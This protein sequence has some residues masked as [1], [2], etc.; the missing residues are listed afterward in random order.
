MRI[1]MSVTNRISTVNQPKGGYVP[2]RLFVQKQYED[3]KEIVPVSSKDKSLFSIQGI[4]VDYLTR[5]MVSGDIMRAFSIALAGAKK[6]DDYS[7]CDDETEKALA[8]LSGIKGLDKVSIRNA[9]KLSGYDTAFRAGIKSYRNIDEI[10]VTDEMIDNIKILVERGVSYLEEIGPVI[11]SEMTFE[12]GYTD[13]VSSGDGDYLTKDSIIDFKVSTKPFSTHW[14][15][16]LLMYYLLG[17]H[18]VHSKTYKAIKKLCIFNPYENRSYTANVEDI[19]DESKYIVSHEVL[20]YQMRCLSHRWDK[21]RGAYEDYSGW[22]KVDGS[23]E[24]VIKD[25]LNKRVLNNSF[26]IKKYKDGIHNI[27]VDDYW[28]CL[29]KIDKEYKDTIRPIFR[30]TDHVTMIKRNGYVMFLSVSEK[31]ICSV[32]NGGRL[33]KATFSAVYYYEN[34]ER[35]SDAVVQRFSKYWDALRRISKQLQSLTPTKE[36]L[37]YRYKEYLEFGYIFDDPVKTFEEWYESTGKYTR[38]DGKIHGCIVDIDYY[39]HIYVNPFDGTIVPYSAISMY[40]KNVYKNVKSLMAK[41][42]PEMLESL[43]HLALKEPNSLISL[44]SKKPKMEI[45]SKGDE[46]DDRFVKVYSH[47]MYEVS[48]RLKPLQ[49]IYDYKLV[50]VWYDEI[51][52]DNVKLLDIKYKSKSKDYKSPEDY[53]GKKKKQHGEKVATI[54]EYRG[55]KDID[56]KFDDGLIVKG[57]SVAKWRCGGLV[58][59]DVIIPKK[60]RNKPQKKESN[61]S[62]IDRKKE[63]YIGMVRKM[64][65]GMN[66]KIIDYKNCKEVTVEFEDGFVRT[67]IRSDHFMEGK[68]KR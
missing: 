1:G 7:G 18:S 37:M 8:L 62:A 39:N 9:C 27:S 67:G 55:Q 17:Y 10:I 13:L 46:I 19:S 4:T 66:A 59:P 53:I 6:L 14:S 29:R 51:L 11:D 26:D 43:E 52:N 32:L 48:N 63:K 41:Q 57:V 61:K 22:E 15:L 45:V 54:I 28:S 23:D 35:Y 38:L 3:Y 65:C 68:V 31:G 16:Q 64:N 25:F 36:L 33:R 50:Q 24:Y 20:G 21:K 49:K 30:F 5:F 2:K 34:I 58:H 56:I 40:N 42:R 44:D 60:K 47:D 12:G